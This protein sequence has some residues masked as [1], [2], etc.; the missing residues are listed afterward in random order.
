[1]TLNKAHDI[2]RAMEKKLKEQL[3]EGTFV[4]IHVEP[5]K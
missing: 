5:I 3:G 1:M 2:T 4:I